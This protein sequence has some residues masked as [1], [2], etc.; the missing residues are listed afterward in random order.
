MNKTVKDKSILV[1]DERLVKRKN[2][3]S[4]NEMN[5]DMK[6]LNHKLFDNIF[7]KIVR[8]HRP[9]HKVA[10]LS[11][12]TST[13][14]YHRG[15][16]WKKFISEFGDRAD[17]IVVSSGGII[18]Q[19]YFCSFPFLNYDGDSAKSANLL[20]AKKLEKRLLKFFKTH[21]YD[22]IVA[23]FRPRLRNTP[24]IKKVCNRLKLKS[25]IKDF[26]LVPDEESYQDLQDRGFPGGKMFPDLDEAI[27]EKIKQKIDYFTAIVV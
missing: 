6:I 24:T 3:I 15:R 7:N 20:Y 21:Q 27:F 13:R 19:N 16:K 18:P 25:V 1:G 10:F 17:L 14:P 22:Y 11:L 8:E 12:C 9:N 5:T 2:W 4:L 23:N 26:V